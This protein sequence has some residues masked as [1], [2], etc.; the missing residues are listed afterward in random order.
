VVLVGAHLPAG[1]LAGSWPQLTVTVPGWTWSAAVSLAVPLFIATMASQNIPGLAVLRANGYEPH[2]A[3]IFT[4][5]GLGSILCTFGS[6]GLL[7][8]AAITAAICAGPEAHPDPSRRYVASLVAGA[9]YVLLGLGASLAAA[10]IAASP[11]AAIEAVAGLALL[12][13]LAN[14]LAAALNRP[15][16]RLA[17]A[18][19][20]VITASGF[21]LFGIG[22]SFWG[23]LA[24]GVL[25]AA[26]TIKR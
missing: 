3:K 11:S 18:V 10:F 24:G 16:E 20:F 2:T 15:D 21:T 22:A 6:G 25:L 13:S 1:A 9:T 8:L 23:L 5:T 17:V 4:L 26:E 14:A 12:G 7:N 19:T